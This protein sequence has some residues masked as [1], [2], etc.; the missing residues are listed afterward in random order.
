MKNLKL[1]DCTL[2]DGGYYN[3][4]DFSTDLINEYLKSIYLSGIEYVEIGFRS[5]EQGSYKG[6]CAYTKDSFLAQLKIPKKLKIGVMINASEIVDSSKKNL[7]KKIS[8]L[9]PNSRDRINFVR[10]ACHFKEVEKAVYAS[11]FLKKRGYK[12]IFNLMQCADKTEKELSQ[13]SKIISQYPI[14][15]L[16]FADS[17]GSMTSDKMS[18]VIN[19]LKKNWKR[20]I[21]I[22]THDNMLR[23]FTNTDEAIK[24]G[25]KWIDGTVNGMGRGPGNIKTEYLLINYS[26]HLNKKLNL[27][28]ILNLI[29]KYFKEMQSLYNWGTNPFYFLAGKNGIHPTFIQDILK[30]ERYNIVDKLLFIDHLKNNGIKQFNKDLLN[31]DKRL[32]LGKLKKSK[33]KRWIPS[34]ILKNKSILII[35]NSPQIK[36][37]TSAIEDFIIK[38]KPVVFGL[39]TQK[40]IKEKLIKYRVACNLFRLLTDKK[41]I[42]N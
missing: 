38:K 41:N 19:S 15:V 32:Y 34:T 39:N 24:N 25:V 29:E 35:G 30:D 1:L 20:E 11:N 28:P 10:I 9:F 42:K 27:F 36:K 14:D 2:R 26:K 17:M 18:F 7:I 4:W 21:G 5:F 31:T 13:A 37:Y 8:K 22:H 33:E 6:P 12:V 3:N 23:A 16:Y 40:N